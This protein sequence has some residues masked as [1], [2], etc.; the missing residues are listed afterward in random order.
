MTWYR[1][2][3]NGELVKT[4]GNIVQKINNGLLETTHEVIGGADYYT[5]NP[6]AKKYITGLTNYTEFSLH[7]SELNETNTVYIR[8]N[9]KTLELKKTDNSAID[10][11]SLLNKISVYTLDTS[12]GIIW[13]DY[14]D[15][16]LAMNRINAIKSLIPKQ[17]STDNQ[18]ADKDFVNSSIST[19][20][21]T[22]RGTYTNIKDLA[23]IEADENDYIWFDNFDELGNR[24]FD[25]YKYSNGEW[26]YEYTLNNSSFT[27]EQ[28]KA[29]NSGITKELLDTI[30]NNVNEL[31]TITT[32][33]N[34]SK[35]NKETV[36]QLNN[37]TTTNKSN[38]VESINE[39][40]EKTKNTTNITYSNLKSLRD[41][42]KLI[43]GQYYRITDYIT[44]TADTESRSAMHQYDIIV[45]ATS[46][47]TLSEE[48]RASIH[49]GDAYFSK[50]KLEAWKIWYCLDNDT[51]RFDWA[52]T[53]N[54][55]GVV[56]RMIDEFDN[57]IWYDFKNIQFKRYKIT[58]TDYEVNAGMVGQY[59]GWRDSKNE[60]YNK[61]YKVTLDYN[62]YIWCY[63]FPFYSTDNANS[64]VQS[65]GMYFDTSLYQN[66]EGDGT[67]KPIHVRQ[68]YIG[69]CLHDTPNYRSQQ[70]LNNNVFIT[71]DDTDEWIIGNESHHNTIGCWNS[72]SGTEIGINTAGDCF[73]N[74]ILFGRACHNYFSS[75]FQFNTIGNKGK[76]SNNCSWNQFKES[77]FS[78]NCIGDAFYSNEISGD[79]R[80][81]IIGD[82]F[83][84]NDVSKLFAYNILGKNHAKNTYENSISHN[85]IGNNHLLNYYSSYFAYNVIG[86]YLA[87][88]KFKNQISYTE[89]KGTSSNN[90]LYA[91][92]SNSVIWGEDENNKLVIDFSQLTGLPEL[93]T[94][95]LAL[96]KD[97]RII[98]SYKIIENNN[99]E[100]KGYYLESANS[101]EWKEISNINSTS[102]ATTDEMATMLEE[103]F[104]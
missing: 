23:T 28:W 31:L 97:G 7:I 67:A 29:I 88:C 32:E 30:L 98:I 53:E 11:E 13:I 85:V 16:A 46:K 3:A 9:D 69:Q 54:G 79:F 104:N 57:D 19:S 102:F 34:N 27:S 2:N 17:A 4:A 39:V 73:R 71:S 81:N 101:T 60:S 94:K 12:T 64:L 24:K 45:L 10:T 90:S 42:N 41:N 43:E 35:A 61:P 78:Y 5:I 83:F 21:A 25:K 86:D 59:L 22:F 33:L 99:L 96:D 65:R 14:N 62:D 15:L 87:R 40:N 92:Y 47:N 52:D 50:S 66:T 95:E 18:L 58:A 72:E 76:N 51:K 26:K 56:Y 91:L 77:H 89:I 36:G 100:L 74:N 103:V 55:K 75:A 44:T 20:T 49:E 1:K 82:N 70:T 84:C 6:S 8:Y 37:L 68:M 48:A 63:T 93:A 80:N 38:I